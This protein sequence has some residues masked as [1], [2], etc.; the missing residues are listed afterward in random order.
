MSYLKKGLLALSQLK[1]LDLKTL[2]IDVKE[3]VGGTERDFTETSLGKAIFILAVPMVLEMLM[4]SVFAIVDIFFVSRL[5]ANAV[6]TVGLTESAMTIVYA[7]GMGLAMATTA[8]V[9]RRIGEKKKK[10]AGEV[11]FQAIFLA[12]CVAVLIA[13]PGVALPKIFYN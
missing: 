2:W 7:I 11:A 13:I 9:S 1:N 8:L 3:A 5:G 6:A 4:E 12:M 10:E